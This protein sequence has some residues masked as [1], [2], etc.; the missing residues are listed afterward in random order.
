M[1]WTR[2]SV[3]VV[4]FHTALLY[5]WFVVMLHWVMYCRPWVIRM[6]YK[7]NFVEIFIEITIWSLPLASRS[8]YFLSLVY[9]SGKSKCV[10]GDAHGVTMGNLARWTCVCHTYIPVAHKV[11]G[12][13]QSTTILE[14][15]QGS[16][17]FTTERVVSSLPS[18]LWHSK[19]VHHL[20]IPGFMTFFC[21]GH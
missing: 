11:Q 1:I 20:T 4:L 13:P 7:W 15:A 2:T 16:S 12:C 9:F 18:K 5:F 10:E 6:C 19:A 17:Q 3:S 8:G 21:N 14:L